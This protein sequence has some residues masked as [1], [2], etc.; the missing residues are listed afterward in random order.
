MSML[1]QK[2]FKAWGSLAPAFSKVLCVHSS[3]C[4]IRTLCSE[5]AYLY[6]STMDCR[7]FSVFTEAHS[8][9]EVFPA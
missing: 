1:C 9:H 8:A 3:T 5:T 7:C 2:V 6:R 4:T